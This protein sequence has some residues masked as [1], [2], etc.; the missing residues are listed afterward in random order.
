M[1]IFH[2]G[3]SRGI[4]GATESG[5]APLQSHLPAVS[6]S[7]SPRRFVLG[8]NHIQTKPSSG[9]LD[10]SNQD[11]HDKCNFLTDFSSELQQDSG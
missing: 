3:T 6:S 10:V 7:L 4:A 11:F 1:S 5:S 2:L 8:L 9:K